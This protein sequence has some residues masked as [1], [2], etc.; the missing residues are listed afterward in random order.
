MT[1]LLDANVLVALCAA[2]HIHHNLTATWFARTREPFATNPIT[3]GSALRFLLREGLHATGA[4][5]VLGSVTGHQRHEFWPDD[6]PFSADMLRGV[7]G[8]RQVTDAYLADQARQR[9][10][11]IATLD[12]GL[13]ALHADVATL[14][15]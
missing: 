6:A 15:T 8:H 9:G 7:V 3:Q 12:K 5:E 2:D 4:L 14:V 13:V 11:T 1:L 10:G